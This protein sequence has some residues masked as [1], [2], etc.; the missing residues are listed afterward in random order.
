MC[1]LQRVGISDLA[2]RGQ[3]HICPTNITEGSC[4]V[5]SLCHWDGAHHRWRME[6][7]NWATLK[8][9]AFHSGLDHFGI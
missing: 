1:V 7:L 8:P 6:T 2:L 3:S 5:V 4:V 9:E